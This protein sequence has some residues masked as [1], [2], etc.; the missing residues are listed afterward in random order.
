MFPVRHRYNLT[1]HTAFRLPVTAAH[2]TD[3][4]HAESLPEICAL[5]EFDRNNVCWLGGGSNIVFAADFG[6]LVVR[7]ATRGIRE[8]HRTGGRVLVE[9]QAGENWHG[10]VCK[11]LEMGLCGLENL[12]L[13][14]GTVGA[15]PVQNIGAYGVEARERIHSVR[16]FD[17][18]TQ[19]FVTLDNAAC[20]F[21]YRDSLF[22]HEGKG[23]FVITAVSFML[24]ET[25]TPR[26][27][28]GDLGAAVAEKCG[29]RPPKAADVAECVC[30][31]RRSKLP[32]PAELG[33]VGSFYKN[34]VVSAEYA[35]V[36]RR[37]HPDMPAYPQADGSLKLAA[38]WLID[39]CGLKGRQI[40][41]AAVHDKQALVLVNKGSATAADVRALSDLI[42]KTVHEKFGIALHSE[43]DWLPPPFQAA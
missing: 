40:G 18:D 39:R 35:E 26:T 22:K 17:L 25:F 2:Y 34:P 4:L 14:P 10:F 28:Y 30:A 41:G 5:P 9:A 24:D 13:I 7:I 29:S 6:G 32:D 33:N 11:T 1:P 37:H 42:C 20:R 19:S 15:S 27:G 12:S 36:L 3:L 16:C 8:I 43:P 21:G 31:I 23:R 38:G